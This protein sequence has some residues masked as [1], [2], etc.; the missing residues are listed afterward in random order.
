MIG[1]KRARH[2]IG[3]YP[4]VSLKVA[5]KRAGDYLAAGRDG[6]G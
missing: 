3:A 5:R 1:G 6:M 4:A 2:T